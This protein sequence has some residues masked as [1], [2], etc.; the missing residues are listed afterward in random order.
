MFLQND[1]KTISTLQPYSKHVENDVTL[2]RN[3][4]M[5]LW[6]GQSPY[7]TQPF[8]VGDL[9]SMMIIDAPASR[10]MKRRQCSGSLPWLHSWFHQDSWVSYCCRKAPLKQFARRLWRPGAM[11][12]LQG[13]GANAINTTRVC[14][15]FNLG[16][17]DG[18][19]GLCPQTSTRY[20]T[21]STSAFLSRERR[22]TTLT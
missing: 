2:Q 17:A 7:S 12:Q 9:V 13:R 18:A 15:D 21:I 3:W 8:Q 19:G 4:F 10:K 20:K 11:C 1:G 6:K 14:K 16:K 22:A 5:G